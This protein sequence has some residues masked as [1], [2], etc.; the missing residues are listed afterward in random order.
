MKPPHSPR[1]FAARCLP[2]APTIRPATQ[3]TYASQMSAIL[4]QDPSSG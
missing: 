3:A 4:E 1:G 2:P